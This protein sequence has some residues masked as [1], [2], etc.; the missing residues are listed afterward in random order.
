MSDP[1]RSDGGFLDV[2]IVGGGIAGVTLALGLLARNVNVKIYE[3]GR[4]FRE[5]GAGIGFTA[6]AEWAMK[7]LHPPI[8]DA[9]K[10]VAVQNSNDWFTWVDSYGHDEK[11]PD[12]NRRELIHKMYLGE[13]GFEG[14]HRADFLDELVKMLP[15]GTVEFQKNLHTIDESG[16]GGGVVLTFHDGTTAEADAGK[17]IIT[18]AFIASAGATQ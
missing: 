7:V 16:N 6:N 9:F 13:R 17:H 10:R 15:E 1:R 8:H 14:C 11:N 4:S 12:D 5:I 3:R 2:A 18:R